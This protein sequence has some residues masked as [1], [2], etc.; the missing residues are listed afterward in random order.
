MADTSESLQKITDEL[1][2]HIIAVK[3]AL[4]LVDASIEDTELNDLIM[5]SIGRMDIIQKLTLEMI[6]V[7]KYYFEKNSGP[8]S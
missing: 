1:N 8:K 4:E 2:E 7:L 6:S 5:K 3:G